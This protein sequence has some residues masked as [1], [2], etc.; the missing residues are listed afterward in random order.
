MLLDTRITA[1][2]TVACIIV[3]HFFDIAHHYSEIYNSAAG[4]ALLLLDIRLKDR[5]AKICTGIIVHF[6]E[7]K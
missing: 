1:F 7:T 3:R 4:K 2:V 6:T 5:Y